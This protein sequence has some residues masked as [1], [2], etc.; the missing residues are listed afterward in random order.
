MRI[1][2]RRYSLITQRDRERRIS[3][4]VNKDDHD[5]GFAVV[6]VVVVAR[7]VDYNVCFVVRLIY[8]L[9]NNSLI[10]LLVWF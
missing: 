3:R 7:G 6:V 5:Y 10:G 1:I 4:K 8:E 9:V 2:D